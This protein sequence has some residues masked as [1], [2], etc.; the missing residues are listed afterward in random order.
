MPLLAFS[1]SS[2]IVLPTM[3]DQPLS[4]MPGKLP[5]VKMGGATLL[6]VDLG[7]I[8]ATGKKHVNFSTG[9]LPPKIPYDEGL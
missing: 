4:A 8:S 2:P 9:H 5:R 1:D 3:I 6:V 7:R